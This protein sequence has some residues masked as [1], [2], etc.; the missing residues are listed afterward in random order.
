[1]TG[2]WVVDASPS[3]HTLLNYEELLVQG[4]FDLRYGPVLLPYAEFP[5]CFGARAAEHM[6]FFICSTGQAVQGLSLSYPD[7]LA[8]SQIACHAARRF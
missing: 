1:M 6:V 3:P 8:V 7:N 4:P 5:G 2:S